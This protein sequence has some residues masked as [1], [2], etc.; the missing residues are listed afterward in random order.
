MATSTV[1]LDMLPTPS[2]DLV[3]EVYQR[4][5]N[6]L[7]TV[8]AQLAESSL[9]HRVEASVST[10]I[11]PKDG[12]HGAPQGALEAGTASSPVRISAYDQ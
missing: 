7:G 8:V 2:T 3:G 6:I 5:E 12:G 11:Y 9:Q 10:P 4:L 1:L